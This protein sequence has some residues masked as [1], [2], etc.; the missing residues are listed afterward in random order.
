VSDSVQYRC[1][2]TFFSR[3]ILGFSPIHGSPR[4]V[5]PLSAGSLLFLV[6]PSVKNPDLRSDGS[7]VLEVIRLNF[8]FR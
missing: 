2:Q 4:N 3:R 7:A 6:P 1:W 8:K 5:S